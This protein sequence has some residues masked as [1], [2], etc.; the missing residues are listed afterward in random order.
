MTKWNEKMSVFI[1]G[2]PS[3]E[4]IPLGKVLIGLDQDLGNIF[5]SDA[6]EITS[7]DDGWADVMEDNDLQSSVPVSR[8]KY[9]VERLPSLDALARP[10]EL[11]PAT[12]PYILILNVQWNQSITVQC[13]HQPSLELLDSYI[14]KWNKKGGNDPRKVCAFFTNA[15]FC[16]K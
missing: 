16:L 11:F 14:Q 10:D 8:D 2:I 15:S 5:V 6:E 12:T 4:P 9:L 3:A 1:L 13:S 7:R